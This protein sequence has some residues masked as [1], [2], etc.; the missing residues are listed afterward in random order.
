M[1]NKSKLNVAIGWAA[2]VLSIVSIG[3]LLLF[4]FGE[5]SEPAHYRSVELIQFLFFPVGV[6]VGMI[7]AWWRE[8]LG[9]W[10]AVASLLIFYSIS[11]AATGSFPKGWA[12]LAFAAPSFLFL[13]NS[14]MARGTA[15]S[16]TAK[17][18]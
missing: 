18:G 13:I 2:R 8:G 6:C 11:L 4:L 14:F 5:W 15:R 3:L 17:S 12:F 9:G 7:M 1:N 10:I 16:L